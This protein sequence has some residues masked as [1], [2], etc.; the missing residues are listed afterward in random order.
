MR[1]WSG[2][3]GFHFRAKSE[4][5]SILA[6]REIWLAYGFQSWRE[7]VKAGW[8]EVAL[9]MMRVFLDVAECWW[10]NP[11]WQVSG[12]KSRHQVTVRMSKAAMHDPTRCMRLH[13]ITSLIFCRCHQ[14]NARRD[15]F[16][17]FPPSSPS[18]L[19]SVLSFS[20]ISDFKLFSW[21]AIFLQV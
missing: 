13:Q 3:K 20:W 8:L 5:E 21:K 16:V 2:G 14:K 4:P 7:R 9:G 18:L 11:R 6:Q 17:F 12:D 10:K 19:V 1:S 15:Q